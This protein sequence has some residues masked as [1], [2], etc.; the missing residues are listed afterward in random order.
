MKNYKRNAL[1]WLDGPHLDFFYKW[2][3]QAI[4]VDAGDVSGRLALKRKLQCKSFDYFLENV[5]PLPAERDC[6][7]TGMIKGTDNQ[8]LDNA[9]GSDTFGQHLQIWGC[10][11]L[12]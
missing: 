10:H 12:G 6:V 2:K 8:C 9:G 4:D 5:W 11:N 1:V 7:A 3:P